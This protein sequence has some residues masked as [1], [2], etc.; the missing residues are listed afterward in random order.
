MKPPVSYYGGKQNMLK[1]IIPLIPEHKIYVEPFFGGGAVFFAKEPSDIEIINDLNSY[2]I[3]FYNVCKD[4]KKFEELEWKIR[5]TCYHQDEYR[6]AIFIYKHQE[7]FSDIDLAWSFFVNANMGFANGLNKGFGYE[8]KDFRT[9]RSAY[10]KILRFNEV[11]HERLKHIT[12]M[13]L[14]ALEIINRFDDENAFF[15]IDPPYFNSECG[16]YKGYSIK[17]FE[18]LLEKLST[19]K[20]KFLLSSYP[21][22]ILD[23]YI[24]DNNWEFKQIEKKLAVTSRPEDKKY[25]NKKIEQLT[26]NYEI[27]DK[28]L[29]KYAE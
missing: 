12:I 3:N 28:G 14:D 20:G 21:S 6:K 2:V 8:K 7:M 5:F 16:H 4:K 9:S 10:N 29:L 15:Y 22:E 19:L 24:K 1:E 23:N 25:S 26:A 18:N 11:Y 17:D 13:N 27:L